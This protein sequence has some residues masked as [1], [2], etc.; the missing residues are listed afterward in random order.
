MI[1]HAHACIV[2]L[3]LYVGICVWGGTGFALVPCPS[4]RDLTC[5]GHASNMESVLTSRFFFFLMLG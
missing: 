2:L 1:E 5:G 4:G 3:S